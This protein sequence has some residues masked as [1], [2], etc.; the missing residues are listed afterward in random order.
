MTEKTHVSKPVPRDRDPIQN[1]IE[2]FEE[3]AGERL[4]DETILLSRYE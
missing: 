4:A 1:L 3:A 2:A